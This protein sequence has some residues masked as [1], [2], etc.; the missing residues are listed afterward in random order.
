MV[1]SPPPDDT[2]AI[3]HDVQYNP[4]DALGDI[5]VSM[6]DA[7]ER[8]AVLLCHASRPLGTPYPDVTHV[9]VIVHGALRNSRVYLNHVQRAAELSNALDTT[10]I[11]APQFLADVDALP[12]RPLPRN[13]M[14]WDVEN[15]K[16]GGA[17]GPVAVS[18]FTAMDCLLRQV[19]QATWPTEP[20]DSATMGS[21][22]TVVIVGNSAGGQFVNRY[23]AVGRGPR[24]LEA[25]G[26]RTRFLISNPSTYVYFSADRPVDVAD[27]SGVNRWRYGFDDPVSYVDGTVRQY[28]TVYLNRDV[29]MILGEE[30][31]NPADLLLAVSPPAMAQGANR[32]ERG[33]N[34]FHHVEE[35]AR[36][37]G[38][39]VRHRL[40]TLPGIGHDA[41][42][43]LA[44]QPTRE[45]LFA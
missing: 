30:D 13:S 24:Q 36:S 6:R 10:L 38:L 8:E 21:S 5:Q 39:E 43:V 2:F 29:T 14:Y 18:S 27:R 41:G 1:A 4:I 42:D 37:A 26:I 20:P 3:Q 25:S 40:I 33:V 22:R 7:D 35:V 15:W 45:V 19:V 44:A 23:A 12:A 17:S 34:Y 31:H 16:G 28:L 32:F 9:L 11:V